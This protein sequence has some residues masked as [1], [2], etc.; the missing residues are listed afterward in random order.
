MGKIDRL[1]SKREIYTDTRTGRTVWKM[2]S[3]PEC[4]CL[5]TYMY[6]Q[7]FTR[8]GRY[9]VFASDRTGT[10]ELYRLEVASGETVQLTDSR[11]GEGDDKT[12]TRYTVHPNGREVVYRDGRR[13]WAIDLETLAERLIAEGTEPAWR[14]V[15]YPTLSGDGTRIVSMYQH[16][17]GRR[18]LAHMLFEGGAVEDIFRWDNPE[19]TMSHIQGATAPGYVVSFVIGPDRQNDPEETPE[20]RAR[21]WK[22]DVTTGQVETLLVMPP[23]HRATHEYWGPDG[24][25]Y[26]HKKS[27]PGWTPTSIASMDVS[28]M[29]F[30]DHCVSQDR[31]L[32]HSCISPDGRRMLV[33]TYENAFEFQIDVSDPA[34]NLDRNLVEGID[35]REIELVHLRQQEAIAY[36]ND[37]FIY[38]TEAGTGRSPLMRVRCRR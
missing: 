6:F 28:G 1:I 17:N 29:D 25:L 23:G 35:Y 3:W 13:F 31:K 9:M 15:S 19:E 32:G 26:F 21:A 37:G 5:A 2:T 20:H 22:V 24:R 34:L 12:V 8:D 7:S 11:A 4:H 16:E 18:G 30:R 14:P 10:Y 38:G 27:V 33:L 36:T